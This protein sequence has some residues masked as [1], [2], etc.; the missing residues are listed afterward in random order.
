MAMRRNDEPVST[1]DQQSTFLETSVDAKLK[2][3]IAV[4]EQQSSIDV[5]IELISRWDD[6]TVADELMKRPYLA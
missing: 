5:G 4:I 3:A 2:A 1:H 6:L